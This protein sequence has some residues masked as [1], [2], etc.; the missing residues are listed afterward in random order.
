[1]QNCTVTRVTASRNTVARAKQPESNKSEERPHHMPLCVLLI[2]I[3]DT[4]YAEFL[5]AIQLTAKPY[6]VGIYV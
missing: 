1:M 2:P 4:T 5:Y 6:V 3:R